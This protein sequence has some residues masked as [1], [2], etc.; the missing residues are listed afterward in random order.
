MASPFSI[1]RRHQRV[2]LAVLGVVVMIGFV[3]LPAI[4]QMQQYSRGRTNNPVV[5]KWNGGQLT[6]AELASKR[7]TRSNL[8]R[9]IQ[10]LQEDARKTGPRCAVE[11]C[12]GHS[13][14]R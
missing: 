1:F 4:I 10:Q 8:L 6:E 12:R 14:H 11:H 3:V 13:E 9:F 5:L 2:S 7:H